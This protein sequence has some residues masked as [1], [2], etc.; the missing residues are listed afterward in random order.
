VKYEWIIQLFLQL[1]ALHPPKS[2]S[3]FHIHTMDL[4]T[5]G[6]LGLGFT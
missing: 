1:A 5:K 2:R 4:S 3:P 6:S